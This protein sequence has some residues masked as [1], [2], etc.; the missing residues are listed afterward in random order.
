MD[1]AVIDFIGRKKYNELVKKH[2]LATKKWTRYNTK[3]FFKDIDRA[4]RDKKKELTKREKMLYKYDSKV[5]KNKKHLFD[6]I[7]IRLVIAS[8]VLLIVLIMIYILL[9]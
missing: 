5:F 9:T 2:N 1:N 3:P 6:S 4:I 8:I 7:D